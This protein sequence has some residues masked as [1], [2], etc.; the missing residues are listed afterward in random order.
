MIIAGNNTASKLVY[1][2]T[3]SDSNIHLIDIF[4]IISNKVYHITYAAEVNEFANYLP[5]IQNIIDSFKLIDLQKTAT[6]IL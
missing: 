6:L 1:T 5:V 3:L 2:M 4:A